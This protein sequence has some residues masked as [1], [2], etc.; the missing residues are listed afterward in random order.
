M[1]FPSTLLSGHFIRRYKRFFVDIELDDGRTV[2]AHCPNT[3]SMQGVL[4]PGNK[5]WISQSA[6]PKRKLPY[7]WELVEIDKTYVGVNTQNPNKIVSKALLAGSI[8]SL[9]TYSTIQA[10]VKYGNENSRIDFLLTDIHHNRCYVEVKNVHYVKEEN[11][12]RVAIFPDSETTR[13]VKHL[14]ELMTMVDQGHRAVI[15]YCIQ[16]NDCE[17][18][19]FGMEFDPL[20]TKTAVNAL[21]H[22]VEMIPYSCNITLSGINL[23]KPLDLITEI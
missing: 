19:R 13:G 15:L 12:R 10:E 18:M 6:D 17:A 23:Y 21:K 2:T 1:H 9:A 20:Y 14:H 8:S 4:T 22:G 3:G 16:R 11:K 5:V 7:T